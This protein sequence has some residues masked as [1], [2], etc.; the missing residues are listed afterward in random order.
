MLKEKR[1]KKKSHE[2]NILKKE[3]KKTNNANGANN[4]N[5]TDVDFFDRDKAPTATIRDIRY[6]RLSLSSYCLPLFAADTG[7]EEHV[8]CLINDVSMGRLAVQKLRSLRL[9]SPQTR[10]LPGRRGRERQRN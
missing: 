1:N 2:E 6:Q 3:E 8:R 10:V 7:I 9:S 4:A 5:N